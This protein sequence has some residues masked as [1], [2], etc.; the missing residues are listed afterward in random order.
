MTKRSELIEG[1]QE[2]FQLIRR[3]LMSKDLMGAHKKLSSIT[4]SQ[5]GVLRVIHIRERVSTKELAAQLDISSSAATQLVDGLVENGNLKRSDNPADR[6][7]QYIELSGAAKK[8]MKLM[9][10]LYLKRL[11]ELFSGL[12]DAEL[13]QYLRLSTKVTGHIA[14]KS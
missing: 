4:P 12:S 10:K 14:P 3:K 1:L 8:H 2:S 11:S 5:W 7:S 9:R 13:E 6:R